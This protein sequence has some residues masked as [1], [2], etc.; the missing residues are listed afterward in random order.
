MRASLLT[1]LLVAALPLSGCSSSTVVDFGGGGAGAG[2]GAGNGDGS[3]G[4]SSCLAQGDCQGGGECCSGQCDGGQ[5]VTT[6]LGGG[7][8]CDYSTSCCSGSCQAG[9]CTA[10]TVPTCEGDGAACTTGSDCCSGMCTGQVCGAPTGN[11]SH[12][13]C[14]EGE[15][16]AAGCSACVSSVCGS[17]PYCCTGQWVAACVSLVPMLCDQGC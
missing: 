2:T 6:C 7:A 3:G 15:A 4:F 5:C 1:A 9:Q 13:V 14:M 17:E 10:A 8:L 11:C 12:D 16:L